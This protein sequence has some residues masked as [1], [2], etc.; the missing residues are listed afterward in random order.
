MATD[1]AEGTAS[2]QGTAHK[3]LKRARASESGEA[4]LER[5]QSRPANHEAK[6]P[7]LTEMSTPELEELLSD[8]QHKL[9]GNPRDLTRTISGTIREVNLLAQILYLTAVTILVHQVIVPAGIF[10]ILLLLLAGSFGAPAGNRNRFNGAV[11]IIITAVS[12][13]RRIKGDVLRD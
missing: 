5:L 2:K 7:S 8:K 4:S 1:N 11:V 13:M 9:L 10:G 6:D 3:R 12:S